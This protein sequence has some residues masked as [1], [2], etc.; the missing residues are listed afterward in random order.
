MTPEHK[1][2][3][4][5]I[6]LENQALK[7]LEALKKTSDVTIAN[8]LSENLYQQYISQQ[9]L[10]AKNGNIIDATKLEN[11]LGWKAEKVNCEAREATLGCETFDTGIVKTVEWY[12][13]K[14]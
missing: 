13:G 14:Y 3:F 10:G 5:I 4:E 12:W 11:E 1:E 7:D 9:Q 2:Y 8:R 6:S